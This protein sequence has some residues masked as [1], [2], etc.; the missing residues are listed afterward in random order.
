MLGGAEVL[1]QP[2][3]GVHARM[4]DLP[5]AIEQHHGRARRR[6]GGQRADEV[7]PSLRDPPR[8]LEAGTHEIR[9]AGAPGARWET[10]ER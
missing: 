9:S 8:T 4:L 3:F 1:G 2:A 5:V 10:H 6:I 7:L